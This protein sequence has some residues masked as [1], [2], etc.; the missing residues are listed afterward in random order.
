RALGGSAELRGNGVVVTRDAL[1][2]SGGWPADALTEDLELSTRLALAG[3]GVVP[4]VELVVREA[5]VAGLA[6]LWTQRVRWAEGSA[7]RYLGLGPS[8]V[9]SPGLAIRRRL[10]LLAYGAQLALPGVVL[11]AAA[12]V[13]LPIRGRRRSAVPAL[14]VG[15]YA[16]TAVAVAG[17]AIAELEPDGRPPVGSIAVRA[18]RTAVFSGL[19]LLVVPVALLRIAL[20]GGEL[21]YRKTTHRRV[22]C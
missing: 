20:V 13:F 3:V 4:S 19:W 5:P 22:D 2:R 14:L 16:L 17:V 12:A 8:I 9:R 6:A 15:S 1:Q 18:V 11:G 21:R 7:R 10:D